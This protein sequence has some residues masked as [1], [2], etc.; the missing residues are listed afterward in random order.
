VL[1]SISGPK[2]EEV[3]GG[4]RR[5]HN[6]KFR[7]LYASGNIIRAIKSRRTRW[8]G[9]V[10]RMGE[11]R[12]EYKVLVGKPEG[13]RPLGRPKHRWEDILEWILGK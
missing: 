4:Q 9:H 10:A 6:E 13:K 1:R 7:N 2:R 11:M 5:P 3:A 8:P 12:N